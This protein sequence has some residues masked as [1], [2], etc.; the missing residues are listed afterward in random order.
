M[1]QNF[2]THDEKETFMVKCVK[3]NKELKNIMKMQ[4]ID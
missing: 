2:R 3:N 4:Y 1:N